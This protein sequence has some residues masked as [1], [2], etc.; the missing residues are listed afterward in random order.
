[1][2]R[3]SLLAVVALCF[4]QSIFGWGAVGHDAVCAIADHNLKP[5]ARRE[6]HKILDGH[7]IV[8]YSSWMD[9]L[10]NVDGYEAT[11][12]WHYANVDE[13][14]SYETM[15]KNPKGDVVTA[16]NDCIK[17]LQQR[18]ICDSLRSTYTKYL[19]HL[20]GDLHCPMHAGR[21]SD[22]GGNQM[23]VKWFGQSTNLHSVWD[24]RMISSAR[25]WGYKEWTQQLDR[26][27]RK[28]RKS[29]MRGTYREWFKETVDGAASIYEYVESIG[30]EEPNL[31]YQFV[32]DFSPLLEDRLLTGGYRLAYVLN[33]IFG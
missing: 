25:K 7:T 17:T 3:F 12:T 21:L 22:R 1:M 20:V 23:K 2:K 27:S 10:R 26:T 19:I 14:K 28:Y 24:S 15:R 29:V 9:Y 30:E 11:Y 8:Y 16:I 32:Y 18:D 13:G 6:L 31:S 4:S 33:T 5:K